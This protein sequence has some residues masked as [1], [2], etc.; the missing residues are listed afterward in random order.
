MTTKL[1]LSC[2]GC[3]A[4][5]KSDKYLRRRFHGVSGKSH[6]FGTFEYDLPQNI[7]PDGWIVF[8]PYTGCTYCPTCWAE[9]K[10]GQA[11][12]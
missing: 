6:G 9:I 10:D 11:T 12:G 2:D 4:E 8:D 5:T 7:A 3:H 1:W